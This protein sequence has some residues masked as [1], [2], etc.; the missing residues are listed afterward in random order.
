MAMAQYPEFSE[1]ALEQRP[2]LDARFRGLPAGMSE[3]AFADIYLFRQCISTGWHS[4][5]GTLW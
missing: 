2:E 5:R 4:L 1:I 3:L